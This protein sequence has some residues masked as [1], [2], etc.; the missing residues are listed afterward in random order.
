M[1]ATMTPSST[2]ILAG[3]SIHRS[4]TYEYSI[5][6]FTNTFARQFYEKMVAFVQS[7]NLEIY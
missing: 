4:C 3:K 6:I 7:R 1:T 2:A 5:K